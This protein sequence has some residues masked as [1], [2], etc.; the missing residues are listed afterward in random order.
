[1]A[2]RVL[3]PNRIP[4]F[5][6]LQYKSQRPELE[7]SVVSSGMNSTSPLSGKC[8]EKEVMHGLNDR[9]A[10]FVENVHHLEHQNHLLERDIGE[11]KGKARPA[12]ICKEEYGPELRKL[13]QL[14]QDITHQKHQIELEHQHLEEELSKLRGQR[15]QEAR[16]RADAGSNIVVLRRDINGAYQAKLQLDK[17]A[18]ALVDEILFLKG[19]HKAEVSEMFDQIQNAQVTVKAQAFGNPGVTAAL[20]DV[21]AQLEGQTVSDVQQMGE[22]FR[23]QFARL[24]E[25]AERKSEAVKAT[26][27]EIQEH[28][29][30]LQARNTELDCAQGTREALDTHLHDVEDH[31]KEEMIHY[32]V[33]WFFCQTQDVLKPCSVFPCSPLSHCRTQSKN[34]KTSS[35]I[36]NLT[37]LVTC[38]IT[39]TC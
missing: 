6:Y 32:Q 31:H 16:G 15:E 2:N 7:S 17:K 12:S 35:S 13:R 37:C 4:R 22:T 8:N 39:R 27:Q 10:G 9:L 28:R 25:A 23:S 36:A 18:Q 26:Q 29:R 30:R 21:R 3:S 1:M 14:V 20:R 33:R 5:E 19:H 34:L 11:I 38:E 24:T